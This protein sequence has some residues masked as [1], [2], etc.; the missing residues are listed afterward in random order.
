MVASNSSSPSVPS[1]M[2]DGDG[3]DDA[4]HANK[5]RRERSAVADLLWEYCLAVV[6]EYSPSSNGDGETSGKLIRVLRFLSGALSHADD[7]RIRVRFGE[8][9]LTLL[10]GSGGKKRKG[11]GGA[12]SAEVVG[13]T[14]ST[15]SACLERTERE[16]EQEDEVHRGAGETTKFAARSLAFLLQ[17]R[18]A[19]SAAAEGDL[20]AAY[21]RCLLACV[22]RML[23]KDGD[24]NGS[25]EAAPRPSYWR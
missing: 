1:D 11:G 21:G 4:E 8:A 25:G 23:G 10:G 20:D 16:E 6:A 13:E 2:G 24:G 15:L 9:C 3:A 17:N 5:V 22:D 19:G 14:L 7:A 12:A 18:P